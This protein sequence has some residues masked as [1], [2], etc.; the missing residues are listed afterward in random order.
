MKILRGLGIAVPNK[1]LPGRKDQKSLPKLSGAAM[2]LKTLVS[3]I[4][5]LDDSD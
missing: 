1:E 5:K 3:G 4:S 2:N